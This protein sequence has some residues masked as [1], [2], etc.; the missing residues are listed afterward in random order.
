MTDKSITMSKEIEQTV[1]QMNEVIA[2][3]DGWDKVRVGYYGEH[4]KDFEWNETEWQV[5]N[6]MW[7]D[8][9]GLSDIGEFY[10]KVNEDEFLPVEDLRYH[11]NW[12]ELHGC[13]N[14][15]YNLYLKL[16]TYKANNF[17]SQYKGPMKTAMITG[18]ITDAHRILYESIVWINS[19][20]K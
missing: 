3:F 12:N 11:E 14:K 6:C 13:W 19:I 17:V 8:K 18:N 20:K 15:V 5:K 7:M 4:N 9:V 1:E 2:R 16:P 10:V